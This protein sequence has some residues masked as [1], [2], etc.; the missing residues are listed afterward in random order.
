MTSWSISTKWDILRPC[1][2][3]F[4]I[5]M[6][7][8]SP[9][10]LAIPG[11]PDGTFFQ[12][13]D[14]TVPCKA[15]AVRLSLFCNRGVMRMRLCF[16]NDTTFLLKNRKQHKAT[17]CSKCVNAIQ[18]TQQWSTRTFVVRSFEVC[19]SNMVRS[20]SWDHHSSSKLPETLAELTNPNR[21]TKVC[22][23]RSNK[24]TQHYLRSNHTYSDILW[25]AVLYPSIAKFIIPP[26]NQN[27]RKSVHVNFAQLS[28]CEYAHKPTRKMRLLLCHLRE[29][30]KMLQII[31][32]TF[33]CSQSGAAKCL[34][35]PQLDLGAC[36]ADVRISIEK[37][38][39]NKKDSTTK[40]MTWPCK[41]GVLILVKTSI[42]FA[43]FCI[44][45]DMMETWKPYKPVSHR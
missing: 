13:A 4:N 33:Q 5:D 6:T 42:L 37:L 23:T 2:I 36:R 3:W 35:R 14:K 29:C 24:K 25:H 39:A 7:S 12:A 1:S 30:Y 21:F 19:P 45:L 43:F 15:W 20:G 41:K 44:A 22:Q 27:V 10:H 28:I 9:F 8:V 26:R 31:H 11:V 17:G 38:Q 18:F 32:K 16:V 40:A 34:H